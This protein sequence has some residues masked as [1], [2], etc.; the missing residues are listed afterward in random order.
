ML[1]CAHELKHIGMQWVELIGM[2]NKDAVFAMLVG[3]A[4]QFEAASFST[5]L[6]DLLYLLVTQMSGCPD[7]AN[8]F[9]YPLCMCAG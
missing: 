3:L 6:M 5:T 9:L 2:A 8:R 4:K 7:L 1:G